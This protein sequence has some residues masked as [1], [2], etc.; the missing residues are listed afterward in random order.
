[1][2]TRIESFPIGNGYKISHDMNVFPPVTERYVKPVEG[3]K[4]PSKSITEAIE[5][6]DKIKEFV[7]KH[8]SIPSRDSTDPDEVKLHQ[9]LMLSAHGYDS[10]RYNYITQDGVCKWMPIYNNNSVIGWVNK[11]TNQTIFGKVSPPDDHYKC[12]KSAANLATWVKPMPQN[13][14]K[15]TTENKPGMNR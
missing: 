2:S 9:F 8:N 15:K 11:W 1:M 14:Q 12:I 4:P 5:T 13:T 3:S 6:W 10:P 7:A